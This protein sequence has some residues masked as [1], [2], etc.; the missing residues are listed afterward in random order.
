M[1]LI[2]RWTVLL[3]V[4]FSVILSIFAVYVY[5]REVSLFDQ[6]TLNDLRRI[7]L[8]L[9]MQVND[10]VKQ[11]DARRVR[12]LMADANRALPDLEV[13]L[14]ALSAPM[15]T[16]SPSD[17]S[18][19]LHNVEVVL[20]DRSSA[21]TDL[22]L[23]V[24]GPDHEPSALRLSHSNAEQVQYVHTT[25]YS[26][27]AATLAVLLVSIL[28]ALSLSNHMV[29]RPID[30]LV[31][32]FGRIGKGDLSAAKVMRTDEFGRLGEA[33]NRMCH[34]LAESEQE[35]RRENEARLRAVEQARQADRLATVG[36]LASGVAHELGTPLNVVSGLATGIAR[37]E[38]EPDEIPQTAETI[39]AQARRMTRIVQDVLRF[40]RRHVGETS[41]QDLRPVAAE[42]LDLV[43]H[44]ARKA[45]VSLELAPG[46]DCLVEVDREHMTQVLVNLVQNAVQAQPDGGEVKVSIEPKTAAAPDD[47]TGRQR[48]WLCLEVADSGVGMP[49][50]VAEQVFD[51]SSTTT[52]VGSD[53]GLG[54]SVVQGIVQ[55]HGGW[56]TMDSEQ[57]RGTTFSVYLPR[58]DAR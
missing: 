54:L 4:G 36:R 45:R 7:G 27:L 17:R 10:K 55:E 9:R 37:G 49:P 19:L 3:M 44:L 53:T 23:P 50:D 41:L 13:R 57:G 12:D 39:A 56:V 2:F 33:V 38:Y 26:I 6:D 47:P 42:S 48:P 20:R 52:E 40:V 28:M 5:H 18:R 29:G 24:L 21:R 46:P 35:V 30:E 14:E 32:Q 51:P 22:L 34:K 11:Q 43:R 8:V 58:P 1:K 31:Q 25:V 16:L 15:S